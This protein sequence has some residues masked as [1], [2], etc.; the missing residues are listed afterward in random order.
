MPRVKKYIFLCLGIL[1]LVLSYF[2]IIMPGIPA[3]PFI[4]LAGWCFLQSSETLY[5]WM[6]SRKYI[7]PMLQKYFSGEKV[8]KGAIWF[9]I[10]QLWLSILIALFVFNLKI[11]AKISVVV[12]GIVCS[13]IIYMLLNK[14]AK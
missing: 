7:G 8:S 9:V 10:S 14:T 5:N 6:L 1:F 2:G 12:V 13:I 3:I 11:I 4:L